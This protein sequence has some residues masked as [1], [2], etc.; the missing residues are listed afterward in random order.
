MSLEISKQLLFFLFYFLFIIVLYIL[1]LFVLFLVAVIN[2]SLL[3][4]MY[5]LSRCINVSTPSSMLESPLPPY[6]LDTSNLSSL[7]FNALCIV[8]SF[9]VLWSICL[10]STLVHFKNG[11]EY[12]TRQITQVFVPFIRVL[13]YSLVSSS[14]LFSYITLFIFFSFS[15]DCVCFQYSLVFSLSVQIF[16]WFGSSIHSAFCHFPFF[17][18]SV[19]HFYMKFSSYI[20]IV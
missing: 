7:G 5:Q 6:F 3:F 13:L 10:R 4:L 9:I 15:F 19:K 18:I 14:F 1:V 20:L 17:I 12:L 2:L 11:P 8:M 16:S